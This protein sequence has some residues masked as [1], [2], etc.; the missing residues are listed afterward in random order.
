MTERNDAPHAEPKRTPDDARENAQLERQ[1]A[2]E[3]TPDRQGTGGGPVGGVTTDGRT[4]PSNTTEAPQS[5][6]GVEHDFS[7][8]GNL[9][10]RG[11]D[12]DLVDFTDKA[13]Q[14]LQGSGNDE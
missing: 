14:D 5:T 7:G 1:M 11:M 2:R 3:G 8:D 10:D 4:G 6:L 12:R 13:T 9:A